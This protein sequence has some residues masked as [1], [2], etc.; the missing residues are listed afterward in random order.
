MTT[1]LL[2]IK[3]VKHPISEEIIGFRIQAAIPNNA[4]RD[5][6]GNA[7]PSF[8]KKYLIDESSDH[9]SLSDD[10]IADFTKKNLAFQGYTKFDIVSDQRD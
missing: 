8:V 10:R 5:F 2:K 3:Q 6:N 7:C 4:G 9:T 1:A